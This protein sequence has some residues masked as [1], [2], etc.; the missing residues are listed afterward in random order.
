[1]YHTI[2]MFVKIKA[3]RTWAANRSLQCNCNLYDI[4]EVKTI[5]SK[6][7]INKHREHFTILDTQQ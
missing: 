2:I 5:P 1:M 3:V 6:Y 7:Y 4:G